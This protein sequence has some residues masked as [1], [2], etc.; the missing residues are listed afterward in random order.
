MTLTRAVDLCHKC[1]DLESDNRLITNNKPYVKFQVEQKWKPKKVK[2][3]FIAESPPWNGKQR[4]FYN[5][6]NEK[7]TN[8]RK[9]VLHHLNLKTLEEFRREGYLMIDAIKCRLN[10]KGKKK[11]PKQVL[12]NCS[13]KFIIKEIKSSNPPTIFVLGNSAKQALQQ[14]PEFQELQHYK[15]TEDFDRKL[16]GYRVILSVYPGGQTRA[17]KSKIRQDFSKIEK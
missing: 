13:E 1:I 3:L 10:K 17:H 9:E 6:T 14:H 7:R 4:Y 8:L 12:Q 5:E 2:V 16:S 11:V 15:V